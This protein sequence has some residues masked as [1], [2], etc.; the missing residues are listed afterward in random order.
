MGLLG[1]N[2]LITR[3][4]A[5]QVRVSPLWNPL[6]I[7]DIEPERLLAL[8]IQNRIGLALVIAS[9]G[10]LAFELAERLERMLGG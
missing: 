8:A 3:F 9:I 6:A 1:F 10:A 4:G 2:G 7:R 5:A